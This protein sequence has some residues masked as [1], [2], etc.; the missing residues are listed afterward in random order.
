MIEFDKL[1]R[2]TDKKRYDRIY[3][4]YKSLYAS[5]SATSL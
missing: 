3:N 1:L 2:L 5:T 4:L